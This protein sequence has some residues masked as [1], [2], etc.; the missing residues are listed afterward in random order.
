MKDSLQQKT[1]RANGRIYETNST[2]RERIQAHQS[3][4]Y[5][6]FWVSHRWKK[7]LRKLAIIRF[8]AVKLPLYFVEGSLLF[9]LIHE[10]TE[11]KK[12][13]KKLDKMVNEIPCVFFFVQFC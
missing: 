5:D 4:D 12:K 9:K 3:N 1:T 13:F 10:H 11:S 8:P 7:N 6:T 2:D